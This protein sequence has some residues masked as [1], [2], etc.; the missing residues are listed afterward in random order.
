[1]R[2]WGQSDPKHWAPDIKD[3]Y[4]KMATAKAYRPEAPS[5]GFGNI[6]LSNEDLAD[7]IRLEMEGWWAAATFYKADEELRFVIHGC[8]DGRLAATMYLALQAAQLCCGGLS[9]GRIRTILELAIAALPE[10]E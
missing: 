4:I 1:M 7:P 3:A 5:D 8:T 6:E 10:G 9:Q 2:R